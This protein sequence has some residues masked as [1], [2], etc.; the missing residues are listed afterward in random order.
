M[1]F[2]AATGDGT[3]DCLFADDNPTATSS[4]ATSVSI[5]VTIIYTG[6]GTGSKNV[7][8]SDVAPDVAAPTVSWDPVSGNLT[9]TSVFSDVGTPDTFPSG[10]FS[11]TGGPITLAGAARSSQAFPA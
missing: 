7:T 5:S 11:F 1:T 2:K 10:T 6:S 3:F 9:L 8:V 4:D